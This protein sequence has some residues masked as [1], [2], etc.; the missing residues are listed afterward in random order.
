[1]YLFQNSA[2]HILNVNVNVK[3]YK[4]KNH[5]LKSKGFKCQSK[6]TFK[7]QHLLRNLSSDIRV[8][9]DSHCDDHTLDRLK[10]DYK[11]E[12]AQFN[13]DG[14]LVKNRGILVLTKKN[15][16]FISKNFKVINKDN[17][18]QFDVISPDNAIKALNRGCSC[19]YYSYYYLSQILHQTV[20]G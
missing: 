9:V 7:M 4:T 15:C 3:K 18:M 10:K 5:L 17:A 11:L 14:N 20:I 16:G 13:I 6:I 19:C 1:M 8:V 2:S 12:P